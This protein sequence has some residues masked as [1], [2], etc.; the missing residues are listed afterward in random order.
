[1]WFDH[2]L[3]MKRFC[4]LKL[5][6]ID[7]ILHHLHARYNAISRLWRHDIYCEK[8]LWYSVVSC[9]TVCMRTVWGVSVVEPIDKKCWSGCITGRFRHRSAISKMSAPRWCRRQC[10]KPRPWNSHIPVT[11][12]LTT[13]IL[14]LLYL[15]R[16]C[17]LFAKNLNPVRTTCIENT[18]LKALLSS[19]F[20]ATLVPTFSIR[21]VGQ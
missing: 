17:L 12:R 13:I 8:V 9:T 20:S 5:D 6:N 1:M 21:S 18:A 14:I 10:G 2:L 19:M 16:I 3:H 15:N 4:M 11:D 7:M